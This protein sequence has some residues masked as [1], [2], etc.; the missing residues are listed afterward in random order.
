MVEN[1]PAAADVGGTLAGGEVLLPIHG[2]VGCG[3]VLGERGG[4]ENGFDE[5][6]SFGLF[7]PGGLIVGQGL[8]AQGPQGFL[9]YGGVLVL[10]ERYEVIKV[11][12]GDGGKARDGFGPLLCRVL[13]VLGEA[14]QDVFADC[15]MT[16]QHAQG[17][18]GEIIVS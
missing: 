16:A 14:S 10:S 13:F 15:G 12:V 1:A 8:V 2:G 4:I 9:G 6:T 7:D 11:F 18:H 17:F 5:I 3:A